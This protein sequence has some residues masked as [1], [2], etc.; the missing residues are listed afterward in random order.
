MPPMDQPLALRLPKAVRVALEA[1]ARDD[2]QTPSA[3][4]RAAVVADLRRR[5]YLPQ[6]EPAHG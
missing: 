1:C 4:A 3:I 2:V 6:P 5:G